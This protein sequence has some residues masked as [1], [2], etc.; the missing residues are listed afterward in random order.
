MTDRQPAVL[1]VEG[2]KARSQAL[3][4]CLRGYDGGRLARE[5][6]FVELDC[7][8]AL[9][10]W[11]EEN[12]DR[13][14]S[15]I[16]QGVEYTGVADTRKLVGY[17]ELRYPV[18]KDFDARAYQGLVIYALM[19]E[20][21][22]DPVV[23]VL[24]VSRE[25]ETQQ[26]QRFYNFMLYPAQGVCH[27]LHAPG[28]ADALESVAERADA[29]AL[30]PLDEKRRR[31]W[32][33]FHKMVIGRA[34]KMVCLAHDIERLGPGEA[35]V[36]ILGRPGAGKELVANALHR[37]SRRFRADDQFRAYPS[38]VN[39]AALDR[40]LVEVELFGHARGA[41]TGSFGER[42]GVF[43]FGNGSTV[44]LDE[45]GEIG[46]E[47][48]VKLLRTIENRRVRRIGSTAE[49]PV[50]IRV[51]AATNRPVNDLAVAFR[52]DFYTRVVQECLLVPTLVERWQGETEQVIEADLR[53][54]FQFLVDEW[55]AG[56]QRVRRLGIDDGAVRFLLQLAAEFVRG[57]NTVFNG[58][59]RSLR[60]VLEQAWERAQY[61]GSK[62]V[63]VGH[64]MT[65]VSVQRFIDRTEPETPVGRQTVGSIVGSLN[66]KAVEKRVI[67]EALERSGN[68]YTQA[69]ELLGLHRDTLRRK[70]NEY[71]I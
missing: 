24:L 65:T 34:R 21:G 31:H 25:P 66:M 29:N 71:G 43:E 50:D 37:C 69:A 11:Y 15:L 4:D 10:D 7:Y 20:T 67:I 49:V 36:L 13:F 39:I 5:F 16:L 1:V 54:I 38:A 53:E 47:I 63:T 22:I 41:F 62:L 45:I 33:S 8:A 30:R 42:P 51:I 44:F 68:S 40:N 23:P 57:E 6:E 19:R 52:P 14:V 58:N 27:L 17:P 26:A 28:E 3:L 12:P 64:I 60:A 18:P 59:V 55:N 48:Q 56:P 32:R 9:R 35:V 46:R 61:D 2:L 70:L